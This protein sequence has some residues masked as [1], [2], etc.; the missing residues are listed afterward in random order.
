[1]NA[2]KRKG[3]FQKCVSLLFWFGE[4]PSGRDFDPSHRGWHH[5][6]EVGSPEFPGQ[7]DSEGRPDLSSGEHI[8]NPILRIRT[9]ELTVRLAS[10]I[11]NMDWFEVKRLVFGARDGLGDAGSRQLQHAPL[12]GAECLAV[13]AVTV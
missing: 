3:Q 1:M 11:G 12:S 6:P 8:F 13:V 4:Q 10:R 2:E 7:Q 9:E 5:E